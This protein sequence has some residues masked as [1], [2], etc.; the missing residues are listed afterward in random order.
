M[1][2]ISWIAGFIVLM[3][4]CV[5]N[6]VVAEEEY[7]CGDFKYI[8]SED[9]AVITGYTG[10]GG[11]IIIPNELDGH[12]VRTLI[13]NVFNWVLYDIETNQM[14]PYCVKVSKDHPYLITIDGVLFDRTDLRLICCPP[15]LKLT[16][17]SIPQGTAAIGDAAFEIC[18]SITDLT[19]PDS[20]ITIGDSAFSGC[21]NMSN[22]KIPSNVT[23]IGRRAFYHCLSLSSISIP[24]GVVTI[25]DEAFE[26]CTSLTDITIPESV[27]S[28]KPYA[29]CCCSSLIGVKIPN[30]VTSI[31][32]Y[33]FY[34]CTSLTDVMIP[35][36]VTCI[37][38]RAF[39]NCGSL[40]DLVIPTSVIVISDSAFYGCDN[41]VIHGEKGS[42][43][44][45]YCK[46]NGLKFVPLDH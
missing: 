40:T 5:I 4:T 6:L 37:N 45:N 18:D 34:G 35:D 46:Q 23:K 2:Q 7:A 1:K 25:E 16:N 42:Y 29:F 14:I 28:I 39:Y 15:S 31:E 19:I 26:R 33:V 8:I 43:A 36:G 44:E 24:D 13:E 38:S 9:Y 27:T 10:I 21:Q 30:N 22:I 3:F 11:E 17:Y 12:P 20:V 41:L 32:E